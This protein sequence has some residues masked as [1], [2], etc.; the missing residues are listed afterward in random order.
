MI[1][2]QVGVK[3]NVKFMAAVAY[4]KH[5]NDVN[6]WVHTFHTQELN[7]VQNNSKFLDSIVNLKK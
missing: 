5:Q 7:W 6:K 4:K 3:T 1:V 2:D